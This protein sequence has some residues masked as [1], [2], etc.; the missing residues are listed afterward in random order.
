MYR[1][2]TT[3]SEKPNCQN[4]CDWNSHVQHGHVTMAIADAAFSAIWFCS[5]TIRCMQYDWPS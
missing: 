1:S 2:A 4:F 5:Y 3:H